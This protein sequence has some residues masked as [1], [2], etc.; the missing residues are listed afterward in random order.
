MATSSTNKLPLLI[1]RPLLKIASLANTTS[2]A[3][4]VNPTSASVGALLVDC[5]GTSDGAFIESIWLLQR[6]AADVTP[7]NLYVSSSATA[8]GLLATGGVADA[9]FIGRFQQDAGAAVGAIA[10]AALPPV[11]API[12]HAGTSDLDGNPPQYRGLRIPR[13]LALWAAAETTTAKAS[14]PNIGV[15]GG[16]H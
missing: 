4:G 1:D 10:L 7:V 3:A 6:V 8:L 15:Q 14:A 16:F 2:P 9:Y 11:L 13:G 5:T 12:P